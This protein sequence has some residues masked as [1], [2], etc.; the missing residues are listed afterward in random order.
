MKSIIQKYCIFLIILTLVISLKSTM[1][2][3]DNAIMNVYNNK[4]AKCHGQNGQAT[5]RGGN[6]GANNFADINWQKSVTDEEISNTITN[7][8]KKMPSW[9]GKLSQTEIDGLVHYVRVLLPHSLR[10]EMSKNIQN[11]HYSH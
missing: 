9:K 5:T 7:G 6:L 4:C 3:A 2:S 10:K 1:V 8:K 11:L